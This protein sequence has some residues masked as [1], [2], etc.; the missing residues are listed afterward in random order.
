MAITVAF[1]MSQGSM[2][3]PQEVNKVDGACDEAFTLNDSKRDVLLYLES[4]MYA[5]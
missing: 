3:P 4:R 5:S 2:L 1:S